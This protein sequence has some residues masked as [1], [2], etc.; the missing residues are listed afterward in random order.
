MSHTD[1]VGSHTVR[2][3]VDLPG[4]S[5]PSAGRPH[6]AGV[7]WLAACP[8]SRHVEPA[9]V[10]ARL[11]SPGP[12]STAPCCSGVM[13]QTVP[14]AFHSVCWLTEKSTSFL[15][16]KEWKFTVQSP[17]LSNT[18]TI[19]NEWHETSHVETVHI[20][21]SCYVFTPIYMYAC[22][23]IHTHTKHT[24]TYSPPHTQLHTHTHFDWLIDWWSLI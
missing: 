9:S 1:G 13:T 11:P 16:F 20:W 14:G 8:H 7:S 6:S 19:Q 4:S 18:G 22:T 17:L 24:L 5:A 15:C 21:S 10:S 2:Q 12:V 3:V 23:H